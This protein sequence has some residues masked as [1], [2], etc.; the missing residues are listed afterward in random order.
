MKNRIL[1]LIAAAVMIMAC[2]NH[3]SDVGFIPIQ[4]NPTPRLMA[5]ALFSEASDSLFDALGLQNGI[6]SS[7]CAFLV[8][9]DGKNILFDADHQ[10]SIQTRKEILQMGKDQGLKLYGMHFPAPHYIC[11]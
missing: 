11:Y 5:R 3:V 2:G 4:D 10:Q 9:V 6:P 7:V 1:L 8:K